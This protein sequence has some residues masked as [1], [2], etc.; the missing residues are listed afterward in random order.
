MSQ[1]S[2]NIKRQII[3]RLHSVGRPRYSSLLSKRIDKLF[4]VC[5]SFSYEDTK[6]TNKKIKRFYMYINKKTHIP[7]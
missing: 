6:D 7:F 2:G 4:N 5:G 1:H 3:M